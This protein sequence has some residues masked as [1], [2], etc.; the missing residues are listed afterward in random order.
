MGRRSL[1]FF[2]I[3]FISPIPVDPHLQG[4]CLHSRN[5]YLISLPI[6]GVCG[7]TFILKLS[8]YGLLIRILLFMLSLR[9]ITK[10]GFLN[11]F[12]NSCQTTALSPDFLLNCISLGVKSEA[13][14]SKAFVKRIREESSQIRQKS[15]FA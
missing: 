3:A 2:T 4:S 11:K 12:K 10:A 13:A 6:K 15:S 8:S 9:R 14:R 7:I 5:Y 1:R